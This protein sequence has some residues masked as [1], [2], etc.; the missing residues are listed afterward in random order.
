M[1]NHHFEVAK[2]EEARKAGLITKLGIAH[3]SKLSDSEG[4]KKL[5]H[6]TWEEIQTLLIGFIMRQWVIKFQAA[7]R[8]DNSLKPSEW[9][10][11]G[12]RRAP[13]PKPIEIDVKAAGLDEAQI[14]Y[15]K[16]QPNVILTNL[17]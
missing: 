4:W 7:W 14:E 3:P 5:F 17:G 9:K 1:P 6:G 12:P 2:S 13:A 10:Y 11:G 16:S 15:F 8:A